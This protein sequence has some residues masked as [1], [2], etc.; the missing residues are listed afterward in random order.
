MLRLIIAIAAAVVF[1]T[2]GQAA[3]QIK[4]GIFTE[5]SGAISPPGNEEKRAFDLALE[6][7]GN[8][9]GGLPVKVTVVDTKSNPSE[10]V[11]VASKLI[12]DAKVDFVT[13]F[14]ATNTM[15]PVW[16]S[17]TDAGIFAI[18]TLAGPI[19]FAGKECA[20]NAFVVS[21]SSDDWPAAV[22]KYMSDQHLKRVLFLGADYQAGYEHVEAAM[23]YFNGQK[24]GP[25][26][27]PLSQLDFSAEIARIRA[28]K[29]DGVFGF[30]VGAGGIA[31]S[32][33]YAQAGLKDQIPF[34]TEDPS[35]NP[36]TFPAQ[37]DAAIG[38]I[39][40]TNWHAGLDNPANKKF[41]SSFIAKYGRE[42]ASFAAQAYDA[43]KLI[44][45][46]VKAVGGKIED[47]AAVRAALRKADFQSVRGKFR[48]N[49]NHFPIQDL[50]VMEVKKDDKGMPH[51]VLKG[52]S[53]TDWQ[54]SHHQECPMKW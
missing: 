52:V 11:Q 23:K 50:Y 41:V 44:D 34:Y 14:A 12:D 1:S 30:H 10:A 48:F 32:K 51:S 4:L 6:E 2:A 54:D 42:P 37:G 7:L 38:M 9:L 46:A 29:P 25:L 21:F 28:E 24:I 39:V 17:F 40:G 31:L 18:G 26:Y 19:Q 16:K 15:V 3:D 13:G 27:T 47:K 20:E 49:N 43:I 45:S 22:G 35:A 5:L 36:L 53:A 33:Q 8:K